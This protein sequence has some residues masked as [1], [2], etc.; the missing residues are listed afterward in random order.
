MTW[1]KVKW[2]AVKWRDLKRNDKRSVSG[3]QWVKYSEVNWSKVKWSE[4]RWCNVCFIRDLQLCS[5]YVGYCTVC[6]FVHFV[7][8]L[9][10][11]MSFCALCVWVTVQYVF[12]C[13]LCVG[14]C[15]VCL[16]TFSLSHCYVLYVFALCYVLIN[17]FM[18]FNIYFFMFVSFFVL[19]F[20][21]L[22]PV[23]WIVLNIVSPHIWSCI[24]SI[25]VQYCRPLRPVGNPFAVNKHHII[26]HM[27]SKLHDVMLQQ[28]HSL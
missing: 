7:C 16:V 14:Y 11:S 22:W 9:L 27:L 21:F 8:G 4:D 5:L 24:I 2:R 28:A 6:L 23:I 3:V 25:I 15:T 17:C 20:Y 26:Y 12:L 10:Y 1:S 19:A 13:T 18:F